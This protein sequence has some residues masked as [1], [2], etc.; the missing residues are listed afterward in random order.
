MAT[1]PYWQA[2]PRDFPHFPHILTSPKLS[3]VEKKIGQ[4][5]RKRKTV[6]FNYFCCIVGRWWKGWGRMRIRNDL[7]KVIVF[8][9]YHLIHYFCLH[10]IFCNFYHFCI[11]GYCTLYFAIFII[12]LFWKCCDFVLFIFPVWKGEENQ[13]W[14]QDGFWANDYILYLMV[15]FGFLDIC[16]CV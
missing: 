2:W 7:G 5:K 10:F 1:F 13:N 14:Y 9:I 8:H 15:V 6:E 11:W 4:N 3:A 16:H 12:S